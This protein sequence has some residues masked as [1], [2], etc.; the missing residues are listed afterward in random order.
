M[1]RKRTLLP[2]RDSKNQLALILNELGTPN[3]KEM[4]AMKAMARF[5]EP[6]RRGCKFVKL[7]DHAAALFTEGLQ[8]LQKI[9]V[10]SPK[11]RLCGMKLLTDP[12]F[13]E[14]FT[15]GAVRSNGQPV[16]AIVYQIDLQLAEND[17]LNRRVY[18][19]KKG[20]KQQKSSA[21]STSHMP[22][23]KLNPSCSRSDE[24]T[25]RPSASK[26]ALL[27]RRPATKTLSQYSSAEK[28]L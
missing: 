8:L 13:D 3:E 14:L 18:R 21:T 15:A 6:A 11:E 4:R 27:P 16:T 5:E 25:N 19:T 26:V 2:G 22:T 12:F 7:C 9:L 17:E 1:L 20:D 10:Y 23:I 24:A 28:K